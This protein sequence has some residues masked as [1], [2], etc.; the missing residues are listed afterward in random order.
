MKWT[1]YSSVLVLVVLTACGSNQKTTNR[2]LGIAPNKKLEVIV[3]SLRTLEN[4]TPQTISFK[5]AV[6]FEAEGKTTSLKA[7]VRMVPDSAIW[8]SVTAYSVEV[9]RVLATPDS[10]KFLS[11]TDKKYYTGGY[12][13]ISNKLGV[14]LSFNEMQALLLGQSIGIEGEEIQKRNDR[15]FYV[16]SNLKKSQLRRVDNGRPVNVGS[17]IAYANWINSATYRTEQVAMTDLNNQHTARINYVEFEKN[18]DFHILMQMQMHIIAG[19]EIKVEAHNSKVEVN[20]PLRMPFR[21]SSK[22]EKML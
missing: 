6:S 18:E 20:E 21:I 22:Y 3:D 12:D 8:L 16:L 9:A 2:G 14:K 10:L 17:E 15:N 7:Y 4:Q 5:S 1:K 19:K 11:K 13:F